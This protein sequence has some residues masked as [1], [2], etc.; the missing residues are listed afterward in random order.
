MRHRRIWH[1]RAKWQSKCYA[2][3]YHG[4]CLLFNLTICAAACRKRHVGGP[5]K[6][7]RFVETTHG[8]DAFWNVMY[9]NSEYYPDYS[10]IA[11]SATFPLQRLPD[12]L[13]LTIE[14]SIDEHTKIHE[15]K[16]SKSETWQKSMVAQPDLYIMKDENRESWNPGSLGEN[17]LASLIFLS[18]RIW[19]LYNM[20][21][22]FPDWF[23]HKLVAVCYAG[24]ER[25]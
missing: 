15:W 17:N 4:Y 22:I 18:R 2:A 13:C 11:K 7:L 14:R 25:N 19:E 21:S 6:M 9:P 12:F 16:N 5:R 23:N 1:E 24:R 10:L 8:T 3:T 20:I